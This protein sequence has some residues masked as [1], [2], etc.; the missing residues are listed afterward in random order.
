MLEQS[1]QVDAFLALR[2]AGGLSTPESVSLYNSAITRIDQLVGDLNGLLPETITYP[3]SLSQTIALLDGITEELTDASALLS[4]VTELIQEQA[5]TSALIRLQ[6]GWEIVCRLNDI[7]GEIPPAVIELIADTATPA[8]V[9]SLVTSLS[10]E[11]LKTEFGILNNILIAVGDASAAGAPTVIPEDLLE[12]V[13]DTVDAF[14]EDVAPLKT[15]I[16]TIRADKAAA[17][18][19]VELASSYYTDAV[20][21]CLLDTLT[22]GNY[23]APAVSS[24]APASVLDA[25]ATGH[26]YT[27]TR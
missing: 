21:V 24:I 7:P 19:S 25:L 23:V 11:D 26:S 14:V 6:I 9:L 1:Y 17:D 27:R 10:T 13:I 12:T 8:A 4:S 22:R 18:E 2:A 20:T 5:D 15:L 16:L 3:A